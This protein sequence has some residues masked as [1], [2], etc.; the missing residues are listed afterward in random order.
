MGLDTYTEEYKARAVN[1]Y[2][3]A[4]QYAKDMLDQIAT[5]NKMIKELIDYCK[6]ELGE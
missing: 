1:S 6:T 5:S 4:S 3:N 2:K